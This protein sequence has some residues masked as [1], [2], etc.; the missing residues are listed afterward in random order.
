M[1]VRLVPVEPWHVDAVAAN[2]RSEDVREVFEL[3]GF[4][5]FEALE[6]SLSHPGIS[7][8]AM[9]DDEPA[10]IFGVVH[11]SLMAAV[12]IPWLLGTPLL[13]KHWRAFAKASRLVIDALKGDYPVMTNI[14]HAENRLSMRWLRWLGATF[15]IQGIHARFTL[16]AR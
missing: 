16:C 12:G 4:S 1:Q 13:E 10:A 11:P 8:T 2:M 15:D 6:S 9:F 5:P 3:G 7:Y 14:A